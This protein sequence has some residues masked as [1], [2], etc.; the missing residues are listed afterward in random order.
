MISSDLKLTRADSLERARNRNYSK[1]PPVIF[2]DHTDERGFQTFRINL[3][4]FTQSS[5]FPIWFWK[6]FPRVADSRSIISMKNH[7]F[8]RIFLVN[9]PAIKS[10]QFKFEAWNFVNNHLPLRFQYQHTM[11]HYYILDGL[12]YYLYYVWPT[13]QKF[14][15]QD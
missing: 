3:Y 1:R 4:D 8:F 9:G 5:W 13:F 2:L 15:N 14:W 7:W 12:Q 10:N 6:V 11:F